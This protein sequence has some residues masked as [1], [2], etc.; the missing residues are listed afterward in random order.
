MQAG[1]VGRVEAGC[2]RLDAAV[3]QRVV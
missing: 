1:H 3:P 2:H